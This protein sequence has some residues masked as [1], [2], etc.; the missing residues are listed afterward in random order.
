[1]ND[2]VKN[3]VNSVGIEFTDAIDFATINPAKNL[4]IADKKGSIALGKD[5]DVTVLNRDTFEVLM[6]V[7]NGKVIYKA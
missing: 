4:G 2:A 1:M 7:R 5:A 6:T 3:V